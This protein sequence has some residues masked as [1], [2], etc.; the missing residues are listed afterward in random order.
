M[1]AYKAGAEIAAKAVQESDE[2]IRARIA[3]TT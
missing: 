1:A 2:S 3:G